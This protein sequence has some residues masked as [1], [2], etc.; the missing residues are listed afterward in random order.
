MIF[1]M[2]KGSHSGY[3]II[4][5]LNIGIGISKEIVLS[6]AQIILPRSGANL[7]T[8]LCTTI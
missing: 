3:L 6:I 8:M 4:I 1:C 7:D 2:P 5:M